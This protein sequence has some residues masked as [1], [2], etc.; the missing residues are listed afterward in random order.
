MTTAE[1]AI[2]P[3][4]SWKSPITSALIVAQSIG[5][6]EVRI[7]GNDVYW[8]EMRPRESGRYVVVRA[9]GGTGAADAIAPPFSARTRVH[10]YGGGAWTVCDATIYFSNDQSRK[11]GT[12]DRRL[13]RQKTDGSPPV[14]ITPDGAWRYADGIVDPRSSRWIGVREDHTDPSRPYPG[15]TIVTIDL[16]GTEMKA[17]A[18][19]DGR[20]DFV[21]SPRLSPDGRHLAWLA[22]D[23]PNMPWVGT[24][25]YLAELGD[26]GAPRGTPT[27]VA[28][29]EHESIFQPTWSPDGAA[30]VFV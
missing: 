25:L 16:D 17:G 7:D 21:S 27:V 19:V 6:S 11:G 24:T 26:D 3:Y 14:P 5:L 13:Y 18:I 30:L 9:I 28:G 22:W 2:S 8:L 15:N 1:P 20:H 23:H 29:G 10:E 12:P 4:G